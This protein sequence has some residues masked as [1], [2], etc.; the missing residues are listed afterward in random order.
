MFGWRRRRDGFEWR[1]YVRTTILVR[2]K[3]RR[4]RFE[5]AGRAAVDGLVRAG[6]RGAAA[7]RHG[8]A[9]A[10][11][12]LGHAGRQAGGLGVAAAQWAHGSGRKAAAVS[13]P[14]AAAAGRSFAQACGAAAGFTWRMTQKG[15]RAAAAAARSTGRRSAPLFKQTQAK[16]APVIGAVVTP[17]TAMPLGIAGGAAAAGAVAS[18]A[19]NGFDGVTM[20]ATAIAGTLLFLAALPFAG[21]VVGTV[22][23]YLRWP[24]WLPKP[25]MP[26]D[27]FAWL[28]RLQPLLTPRMIGVVGAAIIGGIVASLPIS[29][30][31]LTPS[32]SLA[33]LAPNFGGSSE[34][35]AGYAVSLSGDSMR[36]AG[37][38]VK[39]ADIEAPELA[40]TCSR[41]DGG[42]WNC[43]EAALKAMRRITGHSTITC[44]VKRTDASGR[45]IAACRAGH[46]DLAAEMV[47]EG[48][49]F[50]TG[51]FFPAY[52]GEQA[53]AKAAK[54][55]LWGGTAKSPQQYR[56]ERWEAASRQAPD[57]CPI[58]GRVL[59]SGKVYFL[60]WSRSYET[61]RVRE[62]R[63]DKWFCNEEDALSDG[64][65]PY[66]S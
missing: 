35:V 51:A 12:G 36:I 9:A 11:R 39:L 46:K 58:K 15:G 38:T 26:K 22:A 50:A 31:S 20:A 61:Y 54:A 32:F 2:R 33:D 45:R 37:K 19:T 4:E 60:P 66:D 24:F 27:L 44:T 3:Q 65:K 41:E 59:A 8:A 53:E 10:H 1:D 40:Q 18:M 42:T 43:G 21:P 48:Y 47:R 30:A 63:G 6:Q 7:G 5:D 34:I 28:G 25:R 14:L 16:L 23:R 52:G 57:G 17:Q 55:G 56:N 13:A 29:W 62:G 64:W 49:A